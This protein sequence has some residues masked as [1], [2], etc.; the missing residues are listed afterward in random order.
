MKKF[1]IDKDW[2][3]EEC[4]LDNPLT[5]DSEAIKER[6]DKI[7][8][9]IRELDEIWDKNLKGLSEQNFHKYYIINNNMEI[10]KIV[11]TDIKN[12]DKYVADNSA[13]KKFGYNIETERICDYSYIISKID[14]MRKELK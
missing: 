10:I 9:R 5:L 8:F 14:H 12:V 7:R 3:I 2:N 1:L 4:E 6:I 13:A 11:L